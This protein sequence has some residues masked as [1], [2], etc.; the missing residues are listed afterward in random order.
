MQRF[1]LESSADAAAPSAQAC[2]ESQGKAHQKGAVGITSR[3]HS[4]LMQPEWKN[5]ILH[6]AT[7]SSLRKVLLQNGAQLTRG[8][9][10]LWSHL[11]KPESKL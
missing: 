1:P 6:R 4:G 5:L 8:E 7:E 11:N 3:D 9:R 2:A 10:L